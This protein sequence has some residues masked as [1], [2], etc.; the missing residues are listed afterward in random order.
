MIFLK[1]IYSFKD[2]AS[3]LLW[4][5]TKWWR[6]ITIKEVWHSIFTRDWRI[7]PSSLLHL[8]H[9]QQEQWEGDSIIKPSYTKHKKKYKKIWKTVSIIMK[10]NLV[11]N[12]I[13]R[14]VIFY[15]SWCAFTGHCL[16]WINFS[17]DGGLLYS[18]DTAM[19]FY[20]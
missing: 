14:F 1:W 9:W 8:F 12:L 6:K 20:S 16:K 2:W 7:S 15:L 19:F 11:L 5:K 18:V 10:L 3:W 4:Y 17:W 13:K